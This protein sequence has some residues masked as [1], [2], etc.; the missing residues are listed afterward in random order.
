MTDKEHK[1]S[2]HIQKVKSNTVVA[3]VLICALGLLSFNFISGYG[4][5]A[6]I[7]DLIMILLI[8]AFSLELY[9]ISK[10]FKL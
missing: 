10:N 5:I 7:I 9:N 6:G 8:T 4:L 2:E 1:K 3:L